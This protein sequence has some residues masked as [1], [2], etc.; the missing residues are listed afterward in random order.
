MLAAGLVQNKDC[1]FWGSVLGSFIFDLSNQF[2]L[3]PL[4]F[5]LFLC[6]SLIFR[7][8]NSNIINPGRILKYIWILTLF[9][10][11]K[12]LFSCLILPTES[13]F[14]ICD[15]IITNILKWIGTSP[16]DAT[17]LPHYWLVPKTDPTLNARLWFAPSRT[18]GIK[19]A[20]TTSCVPCKNLLGKSRDACTYLRIDKYFFYMILNCRIQ[21]ISRRNRFI[22]LPILLKYRVM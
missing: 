9:F 6:D 1:L 21:G 12:C 22:Q 5:S 15:N 10:M 17:T 7:G 18:E 14:V 16:I 13:H 3:F 4:F 19:Q 2:L 8:S 20:V 11:V